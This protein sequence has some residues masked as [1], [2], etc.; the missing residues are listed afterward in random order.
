M[1]EDFTFAF[2]TDGRIQTDRFFASAGCKKREK[3]QIY[4]QTHEI[5]VILTF[6]STECLSKSARMSRLARA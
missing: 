2:G 6:S 3:L 5:L 4:G 1:I